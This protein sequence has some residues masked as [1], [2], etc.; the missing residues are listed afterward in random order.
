[1]KIRIIQKGFNY[2][3]DGPGNRLV[4]HLQGCNMHCPWCA[5]PEG[6]PME[7][8]LLCK[9]EKLMDSVCPYGAIHR[10]E[11]N[12]LK[13]AECMERVCVSKWQN[14]GIR[15]SFEEYDTEELAAEAVEAKALFFDGGGVTFSGGEATL[16]FQPL[17]ELLKKLKAEGIS[18]ALETNATHPR[19]EELFP[20]VDELI[21][22]FKHPNE[23]THICFTGM[24]NKMVKENMRKACEKHSKVLVRIPLVKEFNGDKKW[25]PEFLGVWSGLN[26]GNVRFE[27]L[28]YHEYGKEKWKECGKEY[29]VKDG[30]VTETLRE[31]FEQ[32]FIENGYQVVRT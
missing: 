28:K 12:R 2:S 18:V 13:C 16:Q 24:S 17:M 11:L 26:C 1:M 9:K 7:G 25:I 20:Y 23:D 8:Q 27:F 19:L 21:M 5:N 6:M 10:R 29:M 15:M 32:A 14:Q 30:F 3:Q 4:F 22:D 31:A